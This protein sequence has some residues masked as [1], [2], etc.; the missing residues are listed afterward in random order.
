MPFWNGGCELLIGFKTL[1]Y[2]IVV[3][4]PDESAESH[5]GK[6]SVSLEVRWNAGEGVVLQATPN[7]WGTAPVLKRIL[8][9]HVAETGTQ[10]LL[11]TQGDVDIARDLSADDLKALDEGGKVKVEKVLKPQLFSGPSTTKTR[12]SKMPKCASP[13]VI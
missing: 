8:I 2:S 5:N 13:C 3:A 6:Q 4:H 11:V 10:R 7:Y 12:F 9:R 1:K